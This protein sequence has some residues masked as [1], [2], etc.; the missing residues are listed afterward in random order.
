MFLLSLMLLRYFQTPVDCFPNF[1]NFYSKVKGSWCWEIKPISWAIADYFSDVLRDK[2]D[3]FTKKKSS[4][5]KSNDWWKSIDL[6]VSYD[7][8]CSP[9]LFA[10]ILP[11]PISKSFFPSSL[12]LSY[13]FLS[14]PVVFFSSFFFFPDFWNHEIGTPK[15]PFPLFD[16]EGCFSLSLVRNLRF[17]NDIS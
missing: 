4:K 3:W 2:S 11:S 10:K 5:N 7:V 15:P 16:D 1:S 14:F 12:S 17:V 8:C 6:T 13:Y 9:K